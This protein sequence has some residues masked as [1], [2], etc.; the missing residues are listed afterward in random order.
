M[1]PCRE[2]QT[3]AVDGLCRRCKAC[4][5]EM[6]RRHYLKDRERVLEQQRRYDAAHRQERKE[7]RN[8]SARAYYR[9]NREKRLEYARR[10]H[11][12]RRKAQSTA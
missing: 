2:C 5:A 10:Y 6:R 1:T 12:A 9:R 11:E 3:P 8:E 4:F 7:A